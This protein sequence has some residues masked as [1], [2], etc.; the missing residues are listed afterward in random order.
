MGVAKKARPFTRAAKFHNVRSTYCRDSK[1]HSIDETR[2]SY[3]KLQDHHP[4]PR[5]SLVDEKAPQHCYLTSVQIVS[6]TR[7][8][9]HWR[10][11]RDPQIGSPVN[12]IVAIRL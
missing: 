5:P 4:T 7:E 6:V 3:D 10:T 9:R 1:T 12:K 11:H 2:F 8:P